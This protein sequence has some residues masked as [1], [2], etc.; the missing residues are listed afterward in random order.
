MSASLVRALEIAVSPLVWIAR[1]LVVVPAVWWKRAGL[2]LLAFSLGVVV[3]TRFAAPHSTLG[4]QYQEGSGALGMVAGIVCTIA[5]YLA[6]LFG[7]EPALGQLTRRAARMLPRSGTGAFAVARHTLE[8]R[9]GLAGQNIWT[10]KSDYVAHAYLAAIACALV[11]GFTLDAATGQ[12]VEAI[13]FDAVVTTADPPPPGRSGLI[14]VDP[15]ALDPSVLTALSEDPDLVV[16]PFGRVRVGAIDGTTPSASIL[17]VDPAD[18][19]ALLPGG[20]GALGLQDGILLSPDVYESQLTFPAPTQLIDVATGGGDAELYH[21]AWFNP[22]TIATSGWAE[23]TWGDVPTVGALV[24]YVGSNV[25]PDGRFAAVADAAVNAG[26]QASPAPAF[27]AEEREF[28]GSVTD[29]SRGALG[30]VTVIL[31]LTVS[32]GIVVD[33]TRTVKRHRQVRATVAALGATPRALAAA[34][35]I[36]AGITLL[37][38]FMVGLPLGGLAVAFAQHPTLFAVGAPFDPGFT[39]W[40]LWWNFMHLGWGTMLGVAAVTWTV[41]VASS[42]VYAFLVARRT[43]VDELREAI[44]AGVS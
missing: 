43:P 8:S 35:P 15:A 32:V 9:R 18:L 16:V 6:A 38:A 36:D 19:D 30:V 4:G 17:I 37:I 33:A 10:A 44:K 25:P 29:F 31:A 40:G 13:T 26:A 12:Q 1:K 24:A 20:A 5:L 2:A 39:M 3:W 41:A 34:V 42:A 28:Q 27:T 22:L 21:R 14:G 23:Q 11:G 7:L